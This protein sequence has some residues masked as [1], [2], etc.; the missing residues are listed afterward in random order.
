MWFWML[1]QKIVWGEEEAAKESGGAVVWRERGANREPS[2]GEEPLWEE[3]VVPKMKG[4]E[5]STVVPAPVDELERVP[6]EVAKLVVGAVAGEDE[7]SAMGGRTWS[8]IPS[9][10]INSL[11]VLIHPHRV[12]YTHTL[13]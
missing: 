7:C 9:G 8:L 10:T 11:C 12:Q 5:V 2:D 13:E 4:G 1:S 3:G 6:G